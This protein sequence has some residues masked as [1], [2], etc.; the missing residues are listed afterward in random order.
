[1]KKAIK[2]GGRPKRSK[3]AQAT[4]IDSK[5]IAKH[6]F[7]ALEAKNQISETECSEVIGEHETGNIN[8]RKTP[9]SPVKKVP[10]SPK[11]K[12]PPSPARKGLQAAVAKKPTGSPSKAKAAAKPKLPNGSAK[13]GNAD[14][15]LKLEST[16]AQIAELTFKNNKLEELLTSTN[17]PSQQQKVQIDVFHPY[18][19]KKLF[20]LT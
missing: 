10:Q 3:A 13:S 14:L 17:M 4:K 19:P 5:A 1:M 12:L 2:K 8:M 16:Q 7:D 11:K 15:L 9:K 18:W 20:C 6:S